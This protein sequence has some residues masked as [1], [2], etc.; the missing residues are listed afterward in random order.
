MITDRLRWTV[1]EANTNRILARDLIVKN[2]T[3]V[4]NLSAPATIQ[5]KISQGEAT[6]SAIGID[7]SLPWGQV[8]IAEIEVDHVR[9]IFCACIVDQVDIDPMSG[10]L[11]ID[12][13][14]FMGY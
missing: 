14:G 2:P 12:A 6:A 10:D 5:L 7:F 8:I 1:I 4:R 13:T 3:V 11:S 9:R